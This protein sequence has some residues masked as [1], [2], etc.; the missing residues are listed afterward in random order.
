ML[1]KQ[2]DY[3]PLNYKSYGIR[4]V[5]SLIMTRISEPCRP[6]LGKDNRE[7]MEDLQAI[8]S[9]IQEQKNKLKEHVQIF[10]QGMREMEWNHES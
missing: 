1:V 2:V 4:E 8:N 10:N 3:N 5:K 6:S 7:R 9:Q